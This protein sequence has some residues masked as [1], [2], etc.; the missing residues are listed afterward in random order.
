MLGQ[1]LLDRAG[2]QAVAGDVDDV[3]GP[4]ETHVEPADDTYEDLRPADE[5][6]PEERQ[7]AKERLMRRLSSRVP[8]GEPRNW[9]RDELY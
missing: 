5:K 3:V 7:R 8:T 1:D 6:A 9:T 4:A 2:G